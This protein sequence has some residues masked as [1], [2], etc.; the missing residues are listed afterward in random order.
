M[1]YDFDLSWITSREK[2]WGR[3]RDLEEFTWDPVCVCVCVCVCKSA[4]SKTGKVLGVQEKLWSTH[5]G[6]D[7]GSLVEM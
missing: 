2:Q 4:C 7:A 1:G 5:I 3:K 6:V